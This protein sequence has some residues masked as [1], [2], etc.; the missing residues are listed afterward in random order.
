LAG[1]L[2]GAFASHQVGLSQGRTEVARLQAD[3]ARSQEFSRRL[4]ERVAMA[5][6]QAEA[7]IT[8]YAQLQQAQQSRAP[9]AEVRQLGEL[10]A[11]RLRAGVPA[12]RLTFLLA[13]AKPEQACAKEIETRR[14]VIH[15]AGSTGQVDSVG[16]AGNRILV[17]SERRAAPAATA[18]VQ[19]NDDA[20]RPIALRF[21]AID[22]EVST[23]AGS[24]PLTHA[25]VQG[26][27]EFRFA[28]KPSE[29]QPDAIEI[30]AQRCAFP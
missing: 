18:A 19:S 21:L 23:A 17:T 5:E 27:T 8:R 28:V 6:Q 26:D 22:G 11:E 13:Q 16:F 24:L 10:V 4:G 9:S 12:A 15:A 30:S 25:V 20:A 3:L 29:N 7:A 1:L 2:A 14:V